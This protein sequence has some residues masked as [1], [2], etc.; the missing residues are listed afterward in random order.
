MKK[1]IVISI[2][3]TMLSVSFTGSSQTFINKSNVSG[4]WTVQGSP[5]ILK[6]YVYV[7]T[8]KPL[9]IDPGVEIRAASSFYIGLSTVIR[10]TADSP[11]TFIPCDT[12]GLF[13]STQRPHDFL[14]ISTKSDDTVHIS[15]CN[16]SYFRNAVGVGDFG[17]VIID[18]KSTRLNSSHTDISRMPSS[19]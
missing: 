12:M 19:A 7:D 8:L 10:G 3:S 11:I 9:I 17:T 16:F 5:Y 14:K 15:Y 4:H 18:R 13:D 6:K 2:V 1:L